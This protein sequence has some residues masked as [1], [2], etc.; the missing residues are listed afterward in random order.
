MRAALSIVIPTLN[1]EAGLPLVFASLME[2]LQAG[3]IRELIVTDGGSTDETCDM[4]HLAGAEVLTGPAGRGAQLSL[5]ATAS[6]GEWMLFL[7]ADTELGVGWSSE[8][9]RF[10]ATQTS[11]GYGALAFRDAGFWG[12]MTAFGAN[13]RARWFGLPYGD[14]ALLISRALYTEIGGYQEIALMEDVAIAKSLRGRLI[15]A[16]F[17]ARTSAE[18]YEKRGYL[19]QMMRNWTL[20]VR[21]KLGADPDDLARRYR[22]V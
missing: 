22:G 15:P 20:L 3:L 11:A 14:Q 8:V 18:R 13:L 10:I 6:A 17:Q 9:A 2:G 19:R 1:A 4:A 7:H 12:R 5:G 21:Y 16:G